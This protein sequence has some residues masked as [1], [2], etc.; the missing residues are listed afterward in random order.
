MRPRRLRPQPHPARGPAAPGNVDA[1]W[2]GPRVGR[3][4]STAS[5]THWAP[6][7]PSGRGFERDGAQRGMVDRSAGGSVPVRPLRLP[8]PWIDA[9][10]AAPGFE[11]TGPIPRHALG[12]RQ[13]RRTWRKSRRARSSRRSEHSSAGQPAEHPV[14]R[15]ALGASSP[16][17]DPPHRGARSAAPGQ[18]RDGATG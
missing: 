2:P 11:H 10:S 8:S 3:Q 6:A 14:E 13:G 5:A 18:H 4:R 16:M 7:S 12:R 1:D 15:L 17:V 9:P